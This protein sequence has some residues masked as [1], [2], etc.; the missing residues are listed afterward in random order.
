[1]KIEI[2][3]NTQGTRVQRLISKFLDMNNNS[4]YN[5]LED[6][7]IYVAFNENSGYSYIGIENN[8][9]LSICLDYNDKFCIV[10]SSCLDGIEFI[11]DLDL[12]S[13]DKLDT[14]IQKLYELDE[15]REDDYNND[16]LKEKLEEQALK[17]G[18][19]T[20]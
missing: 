11:R 10:W 2:A 4:K 8:P 9:S 12:D 15:K 5:Y 18:W 3:N 13:L 19:N 1:M 17:L 6:E 14:E 7:T 16:E 20:L